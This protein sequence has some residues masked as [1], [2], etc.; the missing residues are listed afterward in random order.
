M[1]QK[2]FSNIR[3]KYVPIADTVLIDSL[4]IL[5]GSV[6]VNGLDS[7]AYEILPFKSLLLFKT[8]SKDSVLISYK[9]L[10]LNF[11]SEVQLRDE[12][13]N[14]TERDAQ[15]LLRNPYNYQSNELQREDL[16]GDEQIQ[17]SGSISRGVNIGNTRDLSVNSNLNL[18]LAGKF[19][20]VEV[21]AAVTDNNIPIQPQ[22]NTQTLQE[23]DKVFVQFSKDGH[24]LIAGDFQ[25]EESDDYFLKYNKKAQGLSYTGN[26]KSKIFGKPAD[27]AVKV[28]AALSRGKFA[29]NQ[30]VGVEGNQGPYQLRGAENEQFII[31]LSATE[32]VFIDGVLVKR[33]MDNDYTIDY[34]TAE[35]TFTTNRLITKDI[36]IV[37]EFQYSDQNYG[38]SLLNT[39]NTFKHDKGKFFVNFYSEQDMRFQQLQQTLSDEEIQILSDAGDS[40]QL[41]ITN[42]VDS[43]EYSASRVLYE[44]L[45]TTV[46]AVTYTIYRYSTD[47][48]KANFSLGFSSVGQGNGNYNLTTSTANG[49]VYEW[50]APVGG[51]PQGSYEPIGQLISPK[52][53]QMLTL[54][55]KQQVKKNTS[56]FLETAIS[57]QNQNL[58]SDKDKA[59]NQG[60]ALKTT[61]NNTRNFSKK[62]SLIQWK[63]EV[64]YQLVTKTFNRIERFRS[65]EFNRDFNFDSDDLTFNEHIYSFNSQIVKSGRRLGGAKLLRVD[66]GDI[67]QGTQALGNLNLNMWKGANVNG[68]GSWLMAEGQVNQSD[69]IRH[70]INIQQQLGK[71]T[72]KIWE[73]EEW[74]EVRFNNSDSL[75]GNSFRFQV[76][77]ASTEYQKNE[78]LKIG[79]NWNQRLD[80]LPSDRDLLKTTISNN[81]GFNLNFRNNKGTSF[82]L[83]S[84][85][86][87]LKINRPELIEQDPEN[88]FLNRVDYKFRLLKG[89]IKS[90]SFFEIG[91]G[92]EFRRQFSYVEV[93]PGQGDF[94]WIDYNNDSIQNFNEFVIPSAEF[95]DQASFVRVYLPSTDFIKTY[96]NQFNQSLDIN[97]A[98]YFKRDGGFKKFL[99]RWNNQFIMKLNQKVSKDNS[100]R[101]Q[102]PFQTNIVDS[103]LISISSAIRNTVYFNRSNPIF[104]A[105]YTYKINQNKSLLNSGFDARE[106]L[107]NSV[108][109]RWNIKRKFT[110]RNKFEINE[111][112]R[113]TELFSAQDYDVLTYN[114]EPQITFQQGATFRT[115]L[116]SALKNKSNSGK[117]GGEF[118][119]FRRAGIELTYNMLTKG[120]TSA[121]F[122]YI[123][124]TFSGDQT[125]NSP[126]LFEML[127]GFQIGTNYTWRLSYQRSFK[128]NLQLT[129]Q[130]EGRSSE[131]AQ[132]V[133]IG[134]MQVQLLF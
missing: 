42:R 132:T 118:T 56:L 87:E 92:T 17:K 88:T 128:N 71:Y 15:I 34:N 13:G 20:G 38:R 37:V 43:V 81:A 3:F 66:R 84:T 101:F 21:L 16:F 48:A 113:S 122:D 62:E 97:P 99:T 129:L 93:N 54:G 120:R 26:Y 115:T 96:N 111:S 40:L 47:P 126:L 55:F 23:F 108:D 107:E 49:R 2:D 18:Q 27:Y 124:T 6:V 65:V 78:Q 7:A 45:D 119:Q 90:S 105:N 80:Y 53:Q 106:E 102:V 109:L 98:Q 103:N 64:D 39:S 67:Y 9:I 110:L 51:E 14:I 28:D 22:G 12:S 86:R 8:P 52:Q 95:Q 123:S 117:L 68:T 74:N 10:P 134:N 130:Y 4:S 58:F 104:G 11:T 1:A 121:G 75:V 89:L 50:V 32:R 41:A 76:Y 60:I 5:P 133:H 79:L 91:S 30:I 125:G 35:I 46:N 61:L 33:G 116:K 112:A 57:N 73:E 69:F 72:L 24:Q 63:N 85:F 100:Q 114:M 44:K 77:G 29:R 25:T 36:R 70:K 59:D 131:K 82:M 31:V 83:N 94:Q 19:Q 127:E